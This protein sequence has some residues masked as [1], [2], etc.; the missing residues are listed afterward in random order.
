MHPDDYLD[1]AATSWPKP[2][3]VLDALTRWFTELGVSADRGESDLSAQVRSEVHGVRQQLAGR[4]G[5]TAE[6]VAFTSGAT[7]SLHLLF[8][9]LLR[10]EHHVVTTQIEHSS[11]ARPLLAS[12]RELTVTACDATGR[13]DPADLVRNLESRPSRLLVVNHAS[14]VTGAVQELTPAFERAR[15]LGVVSILDASQTLGQIDVPRL[16]SPDGP[17]FLVASAHK[18]LLGPPGLG[19]IAS[20]S[21]FSEELSPPKPGGSGSS[22][23]L[24]THPAQWPA[25][26]ESGTPNTPAI[27]AL[28]AALDWSRT[29][30]R[31]TNA[32][33]IA[34]LD[35]FGR[36]LRDH[37]SNA[38]VITP[39]GRRIPVLSFS[40]PSLDPM[41]AS[42]LATGLGLHL[43]TGFHCAP[44]I[45]R[46]LGTDDAG[47]IRISLG[48]LQSARRLSELASALAH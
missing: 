38:R 9:A 25:L 42:M 14:N 27:L 20:R 5:T 8:E 33:V 47:T 34:D 16:D 11:V 37:C 30:E 2:Q 32:E 3:P 13:V 26:F 46:A 36:D 15:A 19:L 39:T 7:E 6:R 12:G 1:H 4:L 23:A 10:S 17:D 21:D 44:W 48:P 43:R 40:L 29:H 41:E 45:H 22:V 31:R 28:G 18:S 24:E 35:R